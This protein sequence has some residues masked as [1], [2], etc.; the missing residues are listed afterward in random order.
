MVCMNPLRLRK[1]VE[2]EAEKREMRQLYRQMIEIA[3]VDG[4]TLLVGFVCS[5][6]DY[7][8]ILRFGCGVGACVM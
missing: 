5:Q 7:Y 6:D 2:V 4:A 1:E 8:V 3:R